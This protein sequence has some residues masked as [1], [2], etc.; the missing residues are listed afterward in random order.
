M[1]LIVPITPN[2]HDAPNA[3]IVLTALSLHNAK[4]S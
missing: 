1:T 4:N 3:L 2:R